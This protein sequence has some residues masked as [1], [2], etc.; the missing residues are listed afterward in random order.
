MEND[1]Y[2]YAYLDPSE[3]GYWTSSKITFLFRPLY[4]GKG[5]KQRYKHAIQ[6]LET[7]KPLLTNQRLYNKLKKLY[8]NGFDPLVIKLQDQLSN[9][10]A[11]ELEDILI[12]DLGRL[13][14]D[15]S[16]ILLNICKGGEIRDTTG[17]PPINKGKKMKDLL[18][19]E[20]YKLYVEAVSKPRTELQNQKMVK[21]RKENNTYYTAE[22][23]KLAKRWKFISPSNQIFEVIGALKPFCENHNLSWQTLYNNVNKGPIILDRSKYKNLKRLSEKFFNTIGWECQ[24]N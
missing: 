23:H 5:K 9:L 6:A 19:P 17:V 12:E 22:K 11:L 24:S 13:N 7:S 1:F 10:E 8:S 18:S 15:T 3:S 2:T 16:G 20:Q 14:Y 21:T 4:I